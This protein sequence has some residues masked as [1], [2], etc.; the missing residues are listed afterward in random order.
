MPPIV[1]C[2]KGDHELKVS[3]KT[4]KL[5]DSELG[6]TGAYPKL[7]NSE[8][9]PKLENSK[10]HSSS[11]STHGQETKSKEKSIFKKSE[12]ALAILVY[13]LSSIATTVLNRYLLADLNL[14]LNCFI[15]VVQVSHLCILLSVCPYNSSPVFFAIT[16]DC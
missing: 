7:E 14:G 8:K 16:W 4:P 9:P 6:N 10:T 13:C 3:Q 5:E 12:Q 15:L 1:E 11:L 2:L